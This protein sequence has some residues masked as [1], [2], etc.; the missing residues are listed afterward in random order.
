MIAWG[1]ALTYFVIAGF[2]SFDAIRF[3]SSTAALAFLFFPLYATVVMAPAI[4]L[5]YL[6]NARSGGASEQF[7]D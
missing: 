2:V 5:L 6:L 7:D 3:G 4:V 1:L